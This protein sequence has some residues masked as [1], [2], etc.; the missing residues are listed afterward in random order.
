MS[1]RRGDA[2]EDLSVVLR[3][4]TLGLIVCSV[5]CLA[6]G[7]GGVLFA[8]Y[9][10]SREDNTHRATLKVCNVLN[11][12][13]AIDDATGDYE[14]HGLFAASTLAFSALRSAAVLDGKDRQMIALLRSMAGRMR[15]EPALDCEALTDQSHYRV[16]A[17]VPFSP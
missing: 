15:Q 14:Y 10:V 1:R 5:L 9:A 4:N 3:R 11:E 6:I 13:V 7:M 12:L 8:F 17:P 16:P 2:P